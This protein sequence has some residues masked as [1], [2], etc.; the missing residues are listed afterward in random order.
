MIHIRQKLLLILLPFVLVTASASPWLE[1]TDPLL[2]SNLQRLV[3]AGVLSVPTN[4]FPLPWRLLGDQ[5]EQ[6]DSSTLTPSLELAYNYVNHFYHNAVFNRGNI[7]LRAIVADGEPSMTGFAPA[8]RERRGVYSSYECTD[9]TFAYRVSAN[10]SS[11]LNNEMH[12]NSQDSFIA[13]SYQDL[14]VSF[15]LVERWWGP[16]WAT[17]LAWSQQ[18]KT[19]PALSIRYTFAD[20]WLGSGLVETNMGKINSELGYNYLWFSRVAMAPTG[21]LDLGFSYAARFTSNLD[22]VAEDFVDLPTKKNDGAEYQTSADYRLQLPT[23]AETYSHLYGQLAATKRQG[24]LG[25]VLTGVDWQFSVG[26]NLLQLSAEYLRRHQ[27][28]FNSNRS[29]TG[30]DVFAWHKNRPLNDSNEE[31]SWTVG[32]LIQLANDNTLQ[33][34]A[35]HT[36]PQT[37]SD[38]DTVNAVYTFQLAETQ[39]HVGGEWSSQVGIADKVKVWF[40]F[41]YRI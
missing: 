37:I 41:A 30:E 5:L 39:L 11:G 24:E 25:A 3:A 4:T 18:A 8:A 10:Y 20:T 28:Y 16:G 35:R 29:S 31:S 33:V 2:R 38:Y 36:M 22:N 32:G 21:W 12:F 9:M 14:S 17:S 6:V 27:G 26:E 34:T 23:I 13:A 1:A 15:G 7:K 19:I 40:G